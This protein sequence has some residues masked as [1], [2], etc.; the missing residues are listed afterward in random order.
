Q[1]LRQRGLLRQALRPLTADFHRAERAEGGHR[2][3]GG[4]L[5]GPKQGS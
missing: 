3:T 2:C 4:R 5:R 1:A